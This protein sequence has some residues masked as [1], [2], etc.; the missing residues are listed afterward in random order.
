MGK[1]KDLETYAR[2][3]NTTGVTPSQSVRVEYEDPNDF[4]KAEKSFCDLD[5]SMVV[6]VWDHTHSGPI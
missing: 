5:V 4:D 3:S 1:V 2:S 6:G